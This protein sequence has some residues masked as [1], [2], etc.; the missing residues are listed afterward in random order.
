[1]PQPPTRLPSWFEWL[2]VIA[3]VLGPVLALWA[4]RVLD[5]YRERK[6]QRT[7]VYFAL[8]STR[9]SP[10]DVRHVQ[11]LNS[12]DVV[13]SRRWWRRKRD[14]KI[15]DCWHAW[16]AHANA[17]SKA[18][19]WAERSND[20]KV[21]LYQAMGKAVGFNFDIDYLKRQAYLPAGHVDY[22]AQGRAIQ[23]ALAKIVTAD[24]MKVRIIAEKENA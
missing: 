9:A 8:M 5:H 19:G 23:E 14:K 18:E 4:Q 20:L 2:T 17:D 22:A 3:I 10:L 11:A 6:R 7:G 24:G 16:L 21:E 13:F 1:M 12:I 15:R